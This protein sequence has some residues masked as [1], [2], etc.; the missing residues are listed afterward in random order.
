MSRELSHYRVL[1]F[2]IHIIEVSDGDKYLR[3]H[4]DPVLRK[5]ASRLYMLLSE[6][7]IMR[8]PS[9][10]LDFNSVVRILKEA[11][12]KNL[13]D[14]QKKDNL[15]PTFKVN[16]KVREDLA[17]YLAYKTI[18]LDVILPLLFDDKINEIYIDEPIKPIYVDHSEFG[19]LKTDIILPKRELDKLIYIS[20][21]EGKTIVS[22]ETPSL[23]TEIRSDDFIVRISIDFSPLTAV[24]ASL[25][26]R[27]I[28]KNMVS[29]SIF[30][31]KIDQLKKFLCILYLL[32]LRTNIVLVGEPGSGKT[33][34]ASLMLK[35]MPSYWRVIVI[36]DVREIILPDGLPKN[37]VRIRVNPIEANR[38]Y[39][40][41]DEI[42]KL[43]HRSPDYFIIGELQ[44][45]SDNEAYFHALSMGLKGIATIHASNIAELINRWS[46]IYNIDRSRINQIDAIVLMRKK[47][48][49]D[50]IYRG[51][52]KIYLVKNEFTPSIFNPSSNVNNHW[53]MT[54]S[55]NINGVSILDLEK[56]IEYLPSQE[57]IAIPL[58]VVLSKKYLNKVNKNDMEILQEHMSKKISLIY[59]MLRRDDKNDFS[60]DIILAI[61]EMNNILP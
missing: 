37:V 51:I 13:T 60:K 34:L 26:I 31:R 43:L 10:L 18:G 16:E 54:T 19:R 41:E 38:R 39:K 59:S 14:L 23:K 20:K 50:K 4:L 45:R 9:Y 57:S 56:V 7:I 21:L 8:V 46:R 33:T 48:A 44:S 36:E 24:S 29:S 22:E 58:Y 17:T 52:D 47:V 1:I 32:A 12:K 27:K 49:K 40:K 35:Y 11:Y 6:K 3:I 42:T 30:T 55:L 61:E 5:I 53:D 28:N 25:S 15:T 2:S